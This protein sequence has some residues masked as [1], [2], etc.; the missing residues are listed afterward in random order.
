MFH[1]RD[2]GSEEQRNFVNRPFILVIQCISEEVSSRFVL[3]PLCP[4]LVWLSL[5]RDFASISGSHGLM[6]DV[7]SQH[8]AYPVCTKSPEWWQFPADKSTHCSVIW[9][10]LRSPKEHAAVI[11]DNTV[12][13]HLVVSL[14]GT[15]CTSQW[16]RLVQLT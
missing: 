6:F 13:T 7:L 4:L 11:W 2:R 14:S 15:I 5:H 10:D 12:Q 3:P 8:V 16:S 9:N 1:Y